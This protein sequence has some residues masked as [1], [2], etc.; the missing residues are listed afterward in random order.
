MLNLPCKLAE[1]EK[2][3]EIIKVAVV[4]VGHMGAGVATVISMI[5]GMDVL[6]L[7][8]LNKEKAI[9]IFEE[10]G[11]LRKDIF[12]SSNNPDECNRALKKG[13]RVVTDKAEII[14]NLFPLDAIVEA[15]GVPRVG[16]KIALEAIE[17][18]P[19]MVLKIHSHFALVLNSSHQG[20]H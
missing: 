19:E 14:P 13:M 8:S 6:A 10:I 4:G 7:A 11:V 3:G 15:T 5:K 18:H 2:K 12:Y 1:L 17:K 9:G 20:I 16:A